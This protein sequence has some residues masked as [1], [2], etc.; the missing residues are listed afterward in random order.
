MTI[1]S[2]D[3]YPRISDIN[4][5]SG[6][7][8]VE[9]GGTGTTSFSPNSILI[10]GP[11]STSPLTSVNL[12]S[13]QVIIGTTTAPVASTINSGPGISITS[14]SGSITIAATGGGIQW[15]EATSNTT[16]ISNAG[17]VT[18]GSSLVTLSLPSTPSFGDVVRVVGKSA[19][20]W[21]IAQG[22]GQTVKYGTSSTTSGNAG[23]ISSSS[24][25]DA[26][27][28]VCITGGASSIF[29]VISSIG[30]PNFA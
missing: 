27:E 23:T 25:Y 20:G 2:L 26:V 22:G 5:L 8:S 11:T 28:L 24:Q 3:I 4:S 12:G 30:N 6:T 21:Q 19:S 18:N 7:L 29:A 9:K 10:S 17:Y 15:F 1:G 14:S 13:G 16:M